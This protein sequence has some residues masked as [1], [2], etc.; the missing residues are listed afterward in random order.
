MGQITATRNLV[1]IKVVRHAGQW[2]CWSLR[3]SWS[4]AC[5]HC[6]NYIFIVNLTPGFNRLHKDNCKMR[7]ETFKFWDLV[8]LILQ[9]WL[10]N[11]K[12][13]YPHHFQGCHPWVWQDSTRCINDNF[14]FDKYWC[15][16]RPKKSNSISIQPSWHFRIH[17]TLGCSG[18]FSK[19]AALW[20]RL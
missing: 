9:I 10:S 8:W 1:A 18:K 7:W 13:N 5:R 16:L 3:C 12:L 19:Q 17:F 14:F 4:I 6:S 15:E 2:N 11:W 20:R